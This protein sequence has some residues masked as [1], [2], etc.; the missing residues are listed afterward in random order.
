M[1]KG[2]GGRG[3]IGVVDLREMVNFVSQTLKNE[4]LV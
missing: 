1:R 3:G 4:V 2:G